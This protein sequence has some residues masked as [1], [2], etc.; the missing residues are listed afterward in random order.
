MTPRPA[1]PRR[2]PQRVLGGGAALLPA[3]H[4]PQGRE[5]P[6]GHGRQ[7]S[8]PTLHSCPAPPGRRGR[9]EEGRVHLPA[10]WPSPVLLAWQGHSHWG[11]PGQPQERWGAPRGHSEPQ[12]GKDTQEAPTGHTPEAHLHPHQPPPTPCPPKQ[13]AA[14]GAAWSRRH[15][16]TLDPC[17]GGDGSQHE[18]YRPHGGHVL[19]GHQHTCP[20]DTNQRTCTHRP[21]ALEQPRGRRSWNRAARAGGRPHL[22][23]DLQ[24]EG[25]HA[26]RHRALDHLI[27]A[28]VLG[29]VVGRG[30]LV[31]GVAQAQSAVRVHA[32]HAVVLR[33]LGL[34]QPVGGAVRAKTQAALVSP[35]P[36]AGA[37]RLPTPGTQLPLHSQHS[38][39]AG[40]TNL[41]SK[42][43][44]K[45]HF[46]KVPNRKSRIC[47]TPAM[48]PTAHPWYQT[49][50][51]K[52][53]GATGGSCARRLHARLHHPVLRFWLPRALGRCQ[54]RDGTHA[55]T[56]T[57]LDP[58]EPEP[59]GNPQAAPFYTRNLS[60]RGPWH[61]GVRGPVLSRTTF[62]AQE[63]EAS[64]GWHLC[65]E[66]PGT[67]PDAQDHRW[68]LSRGHH[69]H[70][71]SQR[72]SKHVQ[73]VRA[74]PV[75]RQ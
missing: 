20:K 60:S 14:T 74:F 46:R 17:P 54:A 57:P 27:P 15:T 53:R 48:P 39:P 12:A 2:P 32:G 8:T 4:R 9:G 50:G 24:V 61:R 26:G 52:A 18:S 63:G 1:D 13:T 49:P 28:R 36:H 11:H 67:V 16:H 23:K 41:T 71:P 72:S 59:P 31:H 7:A 29:A 47:C 44:R 75:P 30:R 51:V 56:G 66:A 40:S 55:T 37:Y 21:R 34:K 64:L 19:P 22:I 5:A 42:A 73:R 35:S 58:H 65:H 68:L 45:K 70:D 69:L 10:L 38:P 43:L 6:A 62:W 3:C 33:Q 25:V